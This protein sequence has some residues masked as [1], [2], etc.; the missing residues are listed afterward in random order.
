[1]RFSVKLLE[2]NAEIQ[3]IILTQIRDIISPAIDKAMH[4]LR[5]EI[6]II[7]EQALKSEPEY[8]SL[9][10]GKLRADFGIPDVGAV[11]SV[12]STLVNTLEIQQKPIDIKRNGLSGGF[13]LYMM[14]SSDIGGVIGL[15]IAS[16]KDPAGYS[17][18]WLEWLLLKNNE[19][20][21]NY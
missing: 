21:V 14:R 7:V 4:Y 12:V 2:S 3:N 11:D 9:I 1:M 13:S 8:T 16:S 19:T 18:P 5:S 20:I 15:D 6:K 17:L 10:S